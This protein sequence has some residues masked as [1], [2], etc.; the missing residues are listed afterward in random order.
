MDISF[1]LQKLNQ[2]LTSQSERI[3]G[4][5]HQLSQKA[6]RT[7][8]NSGLNIKSN[9]TEVMKSIEEIKNTVSY[10]KL[11]EIFIDRREIEI[12]INS[13]IN[14]THTLYDEISNLKLELDGKVSVEE[15]NSILSTKANKASVIEAMHKK[16]NKSELEEIQ[17]KL[18]QIEETQINQTSQ[19]TL[20]KKLVDEMDMFKKDSNEKILNM[21]KDLGLISSLSN[22]LSIYKSNIS[23]DMSSLSINLN[24][25]MNE[26]SSM[27]K[28]SNDQEQKIQKIDKDIDIFLSNIKNDFIKI[29]NS[30]NSKM[31][32]T[33]IMAFNE[34]LEKYDSA[35]LINEKIGNSYMKS[36]EYE[37]EKMKIQMKDE[38]EG[39]TLRIKEVHGLCNVNSEGIKELKLENYTINERLNGINV[40][41]EE[42]NETNKK[43][44]KLK[45]SLEFLNENSKRKDIVFDEIINEIET[46]RKEA[47]A[48]SDSL[49][50]SL[51]RKV[52]TKDFDMYSNIING[53]ID[54]IKRSVHEEKEILKGIQPLK[55]VLQQKADIEEVN[56][57]L[58]GI[59]N[60][61]D[62][63]IGLTDFNS[64]F[65]KIYS[66]MDDMNKV[67]IKEKEKEK[68][69]EKNKEEI[70]NKINQLCNINE[71]I[72]ALSISQYECVLVNNNHTESG[73]VLSF[74]E[75]IN[76]L[77]SDFIFDKAKR[78]YIEI[79]NISLLKINLF[80]ISSSPI[81]DLYSIFNFDIL[82][83][84]DIFN[85]LPSDHMKEEG[86]FTY[87]FYFYVQFEKVKRNKVG[88]FVSSK[89]KV[90][91]K[92]IENNDKIKNSLNIYDIND[93]FS[94][95]SNSLNSKYLNMSTD[96]KEMSTNNI[97]LVLRME[98]I[99]N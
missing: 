18:T 85:S 67:I 47:K 3:I 62:M 33:E 15:V 81:E 11:K 39:M 20:M 58:S 31:D 55:L 69:K 90:D 59:Y 41:N 93:R 86:Q 29:T 96:R 91:S 45:T 23:S 82:I 48:E 72:N 66:V 9:I 56:K 80:L 64:E 42:I 13:K 98:K 1:E 65:E 52:E 76:T 89:R 78:T 70:V 84:G 77:K 95:L 25:L 44:N 49:F 75:K 32:K 37:M 21:K 4:L 26:H 43:I 14:K 38:R 27:K 83:N 24:T 8:L 97:K 35:L 94:S 34:K 71:N 22:E 92:V 12:L 54:E 88:L 74:T 68:E 61:I 99:C 17:L 10:E 57:A 40:V 16:V 50:T 7:E 63:K 73:Y 87:S 79:D 53:L 51:N 19:M 6:S 30:L 2:L 28:F 60:E 5:E 46:L 36:L